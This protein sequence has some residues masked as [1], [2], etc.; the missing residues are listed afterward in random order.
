MTR[1]SPRKDETVLDR[2]PP[3]SPPETVPT[4]V[5]D[6]L[7]LRAWRPADIEAIMA[8]DSEPEV[9]EYLEGEAPGPDH[10][11]ELEQC[12]AAGL[13]PGLCALTA[14][15]GV[16]VVTSRTTD[17]RFMGLVMLIPLG[18]DGPEIELGFRLA[19]AEWGRGVAQEAAT[20]VLDHAF[21]LGLPTVVA[22]TDP[23]NVNSERVLG[24]LGFR[25]RGWRRAWGWRNHYFRL[26]RS[27]WTGP[28]P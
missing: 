24:R 3:G 22:V 14:G 20:A 18:G 21:R 19:R 25:R 8:M 12:M 1:C 26:K 5:T 9:Y 27:H 4:F 6:R 16:W 10:R 23:D 2:H 28:R 15:L 17:R 7:V 13:G 11:D